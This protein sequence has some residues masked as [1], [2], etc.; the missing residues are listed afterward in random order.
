MFAARQA[1]ARYRGSVTSPAVTQSF[2]L[3]TIATVLSRRK[4]HENL[5]F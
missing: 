4:I 2:F 1:T 3:Q 5:C